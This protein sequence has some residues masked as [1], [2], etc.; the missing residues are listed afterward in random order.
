MVIN[1]FI[2]TCGPVSETKTNPPLV[3]YPDAPLTFPIP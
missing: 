2:I 1:Y 3:V